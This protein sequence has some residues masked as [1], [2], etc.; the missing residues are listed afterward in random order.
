MKLVN[1]VILIHSLVPEYEW[2]ED[3]IY[4]CL[5]WNKVVRTMVL[6]DT[7]SSEIEPALDKG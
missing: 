3:Q 1:F 2:L 4:I 6:V 7:Y 5:D